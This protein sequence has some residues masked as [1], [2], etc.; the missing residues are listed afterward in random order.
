MS[1][2]KVGTYTATELGISVDCVVQSL[3]YSFACDAAETQDENGNVKYIQQYNHRAEGS[4]NARIPR[5]VAAPAQGDSITVKGISLPTYTSAGMPSGGYTLESTP[6]GSG[7]SFLI[8]D[9]SLGTQNT[10]V[11]TYDLSIVRYLENGIGSQVTSAV[12]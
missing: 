6:T 7:V 11:S 10:E 3:N 8:T 12:S 9:A 5:D 4:L 2:Y 1:E